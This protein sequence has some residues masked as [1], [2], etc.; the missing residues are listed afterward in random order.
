MTKR[1]MLEALSKSDASD[2]TEVFAEFADLMEGDNI[3]SPVKRV[4][5]DKGM[6][7]LVTEH[8]I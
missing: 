8:S 4:E 5:L 2:D 1:E 6:I 7:I 3:T